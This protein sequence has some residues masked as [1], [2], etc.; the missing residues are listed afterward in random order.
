MLM[1]TETLLCTDM[2]CP[3]GMWSAVW[4][5]KPSKMSQSGLRSCLPCCQVYIAAM[6][7]DLLYSSRSMVQ[8]SNAPWMAQ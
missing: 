8:G 3:T 6:G 5:M 7:L 2:A 4:Q 1:K